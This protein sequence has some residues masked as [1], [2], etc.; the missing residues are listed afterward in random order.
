MTNGTTRASLAFIVLAFCSAAV[1]AAGDEQ[2]SATL[3]QSPPPQAAA[4]VPSAEGPLIAPSSDTAPVEITGLRDGDAGAI[5]DRNVGLNHRL[6]VILS[7]KPSVPASHYVLF[8][9]GTE[10]K[11]LVPTY[12]AYQGETHQEIHALVFHLQRNTGNDAFWKEILSSPKGG[13]VPVQVSLGERADSCSDA[14]N[15]PPAQVTLRGK[16]TFNFRV[17]SPGQLIAASIAIG[18]MLLLVWGLARKHAALRDNLLPQ[19]EPARQPYSLARWQ[20]AFW[21]TLVFAAFVFLFVLLWDANTLSTQALALMG[22][23]GT[24]AFASVAV[25]GYK[26]SPADAA[27]RGLRALG[28]N[29]HDDVLRVRQEVADRQK[30]LAARPPQGRCQQLQLEIQDRNVI[31]WTYED[32][33]RP[34]VSQGWFKDVTTDLNGMALHRLQVLCWTVALGIMFAIGVYQDLT[35]PDFNGSLLALL[36]I[37]G[38]GYVGFKVPEVNS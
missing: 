6:W 15:C 32:R 22:I 4:G 16:P 33:I 24:T 13:T 37:S 30:E 8:L 38:A 11:G 9:N 2:Q 34:F 29:C 36:G 19:L 10:I 26:D 28:L 21:F 35:M 23:S 1:V 12:T 17:Y 31:L 18:I 7:G 14:Q 20:M 3:A 27:N 5:A 25:D